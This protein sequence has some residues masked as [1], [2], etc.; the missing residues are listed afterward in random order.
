MSIDDLPKGA[1]VM[2]RLRHPGPRQ[3]DALTITPTL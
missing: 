2:D 1:C 3:A